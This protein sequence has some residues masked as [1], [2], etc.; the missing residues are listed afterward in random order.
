MKI[1]N[2][3]VAR[4]DYELQHL[5]GR[6][7]SRPS[8][9]DLLVRVCYELNI[10]SFHQDC[11]ELAGNHEDL[12]DKLHDMTYELILASG[13]NRA[14]V[15]ETLADRLTASNSAKDPLLQRNL[16]LVFYYLERDEEA[17]ECLNQAKSVKNFK[18]DSRFFEVFA[19]IH[20]A[21]EAYR[22]CIE[23]C[24]Q[25]I[26]AAGPSA[27]TIRLK[28]LSHF[29]LGE[30]GQAE[31]CMVLAL[32]KEPHFVW[33]CH[34]LAEQALERGDLSRAFRYFGKAVYV[35]P[36][37]A[38]NY[39]IPAEAF[40]DMHE[41][42]LA[43]AELEKLLLFEPDPRIAAEVHNGLGY[44]YLRKNDPDRAERELER[45]LTLEPEL[46]VA[47]YNQGRLAL[48]RERPGRAE[49]CFKKALELDQQSGES[50]VEL[51][52]I[53]LTRERLARAKRC[54][55]QAI[56]LGVCDA[57]AHMGLAR[58]ARK[59]GDSSSQLFHARKA[60]ELG[61]EDADIANEL[62]I[63]LECNS[64]VKQAVA[65]YRQALA[66]DPD[67]HK[68][69]NNLGYACEKMMDHADEHP[70]LWRDQAVEAWKK[71]LRICVR[72]KLST[73]TATQHLRKLGVSREQIRNWARAT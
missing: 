62:G 14:H 22:A 16:G 68:A 39:F 47:Y 41:Y 35:N 4:F 25:A 72:V 28:G 24:D 53:A 66:L 23:Y 44:L 30:L 31:A 58:I 5:L 48:L 40:M 3:D 18:P 33:A 12:W 9:S 42:D 73:R 26:N 46:A 65:C 45:A 69:A 20:Y 13:L 1:Q 43:V 56:E 15:L 70:S 55:N 8:D 67:H 59:R 49:R 54:F 37:D 34:S 60:L 29:E 50:W 21:R 27:R 17:L 11:V 7:A 6:L 71:R 10:R 61:P 19:L 64:E 63:A 38:G 52:F 51:G 2:I 57:T 32:E 36:T